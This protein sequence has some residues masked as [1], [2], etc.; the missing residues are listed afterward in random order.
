MNNHIVVVLFFLSSFLF[1][2]R[3]TYFWVGRNI[4][5]FCKLLDTDKFMEP[6]NQISH[7]VMKLHSP[8]FEKTVLLSH[9]FVLL[10]C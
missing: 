10:N 7:L 9:T 2:V 5:L 4:C 1:H 3:T 8:I 6:N